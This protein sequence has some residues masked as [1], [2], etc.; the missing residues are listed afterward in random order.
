MEMIV[1]IDTVVAMKTALVAVDGRIRL[2]E[3]ERGGVDRSACWNGGSGNYGYGVVAEGWWC[4]CLRDR[5]Q[6]HG[7]DRGEIVV[8]SV[9]IDLAGIK[10]REGWRWRIDCDSELQ[11]WRTMAGWR[12]LLL[13]RQKCK[14]RK[15]KERKKERRK[16]EEKNGGRRRW[17]CWQCA[18]G[19]GGAAGWSGG[20]GMGEERLATRWI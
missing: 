20:T 1:F 12:D 10:R 5:R 15:G 9:T 18:G 4:N 6:W 7:P 11:W 3:A 16:E 19:A 17:S 14:R 2:A 13:S 8:L